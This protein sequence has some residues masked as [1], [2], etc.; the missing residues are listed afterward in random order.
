VFFARCCS[1]GARPRREPCAQSFPEERG[2][3]SL[4]ARAHAPD[5]PLAVPIAAWPPLL[6]QQHQRATATSRRRRPPKPPTAVPRAPLTAAH[7]SPPPAPPSTKTAKGQG[8][9]DQAHRGPK[10]GN[11]GTPQAHQGLHLGQLPRQLG[12]VPLLRPGR[13]RRSPRQDPRARRR[14]PLFRPR[15]CPDHHQAR[16]GQRLLARGRRQGG[17]HGYACDERP[18]PP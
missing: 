9:P 14:R 8:R 13:G 10:D 15:S 17:H 16:R 3:L 11:L 7:R 12:P 6:Q 1:V 4:A 18:H 5:T 2:S